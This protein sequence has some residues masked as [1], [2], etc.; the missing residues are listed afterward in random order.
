[1]MLS[2]KERLAQIIA[3]PPPTPF[4]QPRRK[5]IDKSDPSQKSIAPE[6]IFEDDDKDFEVCQQ[7]Q[8]MTMDDEPLFDD[9]DES[10]HDDEEFDERCTEALREEAKLWMSEYGPKLFEL[11][12]SK[13]LTKKDKKDANPS[14][15]SEPPTK[16]RRKA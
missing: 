6:I 7:T 13:W 4:K 8:Q 15:K 3:N 1:M 5:G 14:R 11:V 16:K 2:K 9:E 10:E 12:A